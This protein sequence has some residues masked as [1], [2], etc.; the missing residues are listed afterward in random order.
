MDSDN[1]QQTVQQGNKQGPKQQQRPKQQQGN[2]Q[3]QG[4]KQQQGHK[5]Q[6][7]PTEQPQD[8]PLDHPVWVQTKEALIKL[9]D[10]I[11]LLGY[12]TVSDWDGT[13]GTPLNLDTKGDVW[14]MGESVGEPQFLEIFYLAMCFLCGRKE[15]VQVRESIESKIEKFSK[16][17]DTHKPLFLNPLTAKS[18]VFK[19][20]YFKLFMSLVPQSFKDQLVADGKKFPI[21]FFDDD[22]EN[23]KSVS[24]VFKG[25]EWANFV[26]F[27]VTL[28][29]SKVVSMPKFPGCGGS[30]LFRDLQ[31]VFPDCVVVSS[32]VL[33]KKGLAPEEK[34]RVL[35]EQIA[36]QDALKFLD[37]CGDYFKH[38]HGTVQVQLVG[39]HCKN[40]KSLLF[41][42]KN[43]CERDESSDST[44]FGVNALKIFFKKLKDFLKSCKCLDSSFN[45]DQFVQYCKT[46]N[47]G[48]LT[49]TE[50][51][52]NFFGKDWMEQVEKG[53]E[54]YQIWLHDV[55][56]SFLEESI[57]KINNVE[58]KCVTP[59]HYLGIFF[60]DGTHLTVV[61]P[62]GN[63]LEQLSNPKFIELFRQPLTVDK[64]G[65]FKND[66]IGFFVAQPTDQVVSLFPRLKNEGHITTW[67]GPNV[68]PV[69]SLLVLK[70]MNKNGEKVEKAEG[71]LTGWMS[72]KN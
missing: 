2:K 58:L 1:K 59:Y 38:P 72:C 54:E 41:A 52:E 46:L 31:K 10:T 35:Q 70:E 8:L 25:V 64:I 7:G 11:L 65:Q 60:D 36:S 55:Y 57:N 20:Q 37:L 66:K 22:D 40:P 71:T 18:P 21:F 12:F 42:I 9:L 27:K 49:G 19:A 26:P 29:V 32:D 3:Q 63:V 5:Q 62:R 15:L 50:I 24:E 48:T 30:H 14:Q 23:L 47:L 45:D 13:I 16:K 61:P 17:C 67:T 56:P 51:L 39:P 4:P 68:Q 44:L 69:M 6:Q 43:I 33:D 34:T 28:G 53:A